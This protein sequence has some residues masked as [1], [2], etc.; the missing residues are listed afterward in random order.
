MKEI[1]IKKKEI[2]VMA[3]YKKGRNGSSGSVE[4]RQK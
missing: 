1:V 3:G 4:R 2:E